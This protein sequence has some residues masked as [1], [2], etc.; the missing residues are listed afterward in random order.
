[1]SFRV[2]V[3]ASGGGSNLGALLNAF[4]PPERG[5]V[6]IALVISNRPDAGA[7]ERARS[8]GVAV[9]VLADPDSPHEWLEALGAA[10]VD[11]LVLA[12]YLR[13]VPAGVIAEYRGRV[14]NVHP[15]LLPDFGGPGMYGIRVHRAVLEAGKRQSGASVHLV[16]EEYDRGPVLARLPVP[17]ERGDTPEMLAARVLDAEH[18]LL[19]AVVAAA[20]RTGKPVPLDDNIVAEMTS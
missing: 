20:A 5:P 18:R 11:L 19:P 1:M 10:S 8:R 15:A 3:A 12:G 14:I 2:A 9:H 16:D 4:P 6:D 17:V 13:L 7:L